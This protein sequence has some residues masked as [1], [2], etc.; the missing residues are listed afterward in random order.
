[1]L[2]IRSR[3]HHG[4]QAVVGDQ[5][6]GIAVAC[7]HPMA[8]GHLGQALRIGIGQSSQRHSGQVGQHAGMQLAEPPQ[9][10]EADPQGAVSRTERHTLAGTRR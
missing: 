3:Q 9:A 2:F 4:I 10:G 7:R 5:L 8:F 6:Q 1:M